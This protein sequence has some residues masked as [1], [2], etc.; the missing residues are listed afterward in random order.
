MMEERHA[1]KHEVLEIKKD[2]LINE[3]EIR[4]DLLDTTIDDRNKIRKYYEDLEQE[5]GPLGRADTIRVKYLEKQLEREYK[6]QEKV[7][8]YLHELKKQ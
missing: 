2:L 1:A 6:Q 7:Q 4:S 8:D 5:K 3:L